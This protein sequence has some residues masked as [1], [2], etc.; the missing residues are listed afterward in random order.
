MALERIFEEENKKIDYNA[1]IEKRVVSYFVNLINSDYQEF[2][3]VFSPI[4]DKKFK[5]NLKYFG[6]DL[7]KNGVEKVRQEFFEK[8]LY[9]EVSRMIKKLSDDAEKIRGIIIYKREPQTPDIQLGFSKYFKYNCIEATGK[10]LT[11]KGINVINSYRESSG[12]V[13]IEERR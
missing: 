9:I 12:L 5:E 11:E 1:Q 4:I 7:E 6:E 3:K 13:S 8:G 2:V 10:K